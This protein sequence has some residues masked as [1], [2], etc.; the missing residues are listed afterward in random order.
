MPGI[1]QDDTYDQN[2]EVWFV[3]LTP[4]MDVLVWGHAIA[5]T[6]SLGQQYYLGSAGG[7]EKFAV[8]LTEGTDPCIPRFY[9]L[10]AKA[11]QATTTVQRSHAVRFIG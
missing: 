6:T 7:I 10:E 2:D 11:S 5:E 3:E 1:G 8:G 4:G 9:S